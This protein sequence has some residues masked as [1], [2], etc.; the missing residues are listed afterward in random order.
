[1]TFKV[2]TAQVNV[3]RLVGHTH[4]AAAQLDWSTFLAQHHFICSNPPNL[5]RTFLIARAGY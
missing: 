2:T 1:M 3:E 4:G 5:R